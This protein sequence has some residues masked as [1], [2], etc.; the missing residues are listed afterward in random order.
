[1]YMKFDDMAI[2]KNATCAVSDGHSAGLA[3]EG[4]DTLASHSRQ[5]Y[6]QSAYMDFDWY[7]ILFIK[8][9]KI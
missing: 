7:E 4:K 5:F 3:A 6:V 1:M 2:K 8:Y 9:V